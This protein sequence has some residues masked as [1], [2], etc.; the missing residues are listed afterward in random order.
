MHTMATVESVGSPT[1]SIY[2]RVALPESRRLTIKVN[3]RRM[4]KRE[5]LPELFCYLITKNGK[6]SIFAFSFL[7]YF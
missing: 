4:P 6:M 1:K 2:K 7:F 3:L 5:A